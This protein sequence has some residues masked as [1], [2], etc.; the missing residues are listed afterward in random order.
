[1]KDIR[2]RIELVNEARRAI[3]E[4]MLAGIPIE[5]I[6]KG[7]H[8]SKVTLES[9]ACFGARIEDPELKNI[10]VFFSLNDPKRLKN[11]AKYHGYFGAIS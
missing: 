5:T 3:V 8:M 7:C 10:C 4:C 2:T 11:D 6:A 9:F 1:M